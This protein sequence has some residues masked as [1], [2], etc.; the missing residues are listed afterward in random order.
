M[1]ETI[2]LKILKRL[3][4]KLSIIAN[5]TVYA[6]GKVLTGNGLAHNVLF[7]NDEPN[8]DIVRG[9]HCN[10]LM[11]LR[12]THFVESQCTFVGR[13]FYLHNKDG[14]DA[15]DG[16]SWLTAKK[17]IDTIEQIVRPGDTVVLG[18]GQFAGTISASG[19]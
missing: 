11:N 14:D 7:T 17:T 5:V 9:I 1:L 10:R 19:G 16:L 8:M 4:G 15:S 12:Y 3:I 6:D 2:R 18:P 13:T